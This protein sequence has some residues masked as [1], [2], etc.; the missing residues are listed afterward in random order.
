MPKFKI[1]ISSEHEIE[2]IDE[3]QAEGLFFSD[4]IYDTQSDP[5]SFIAEHLTITKVE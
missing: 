2:A 3:E 4:I 5:A 1:T